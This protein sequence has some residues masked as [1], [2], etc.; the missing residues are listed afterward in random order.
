MTNLTAEDLRQIERLI[1]NRVKR[2]EDQMAVELREHF[3]SLTRDLGHKLDRL[4]VQTRSEVKETLT[5]QTHGQ[6]GANEPTPP[7]RPGITSLQM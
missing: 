6:A 3:E 2:A 4:A 5:E 1:D 7:T